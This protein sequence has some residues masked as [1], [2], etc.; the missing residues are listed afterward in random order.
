MREG[1]TVELKSQMSGPDFLILKESGSREGWVLSPGLG[2]VLLRRQGEL[3]S[4]SIL[5]SD[6][7]RFKP[8]LPSLLAF[9]PQQLILLLWVS[10]LNEIIQGK[11]LRERQAWLLF[12]WGFHPV[13]RLDGKWKV[14]SF[15]PLF[16]AWFPFHRVYQLTNLCWDTFEGWELTS[17]YCGSETIC[18]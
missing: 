4:L 13:S 9:W 14:I 16:L 10:E 7:L 15:S 17:N 1:W 2:A 8:W 6:A 11:F 12:S 5:K 3:L 18:E